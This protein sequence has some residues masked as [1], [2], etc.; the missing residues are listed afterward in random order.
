MTLTTQ[1]ALG[2][3]FC[4][5]RAVVTVAQVCSVLCL[6]PITVRR[7]L[8]KHGYYSSINHNARYYT[9]AH[10]PHFAANGLWFYRSIAFSC[11]RTL[12]KT[13]LALVQQ[14]TAGATPE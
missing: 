8:K 10:K 3:D 13:L 14:A 9:L 7:A 5:R 4:K 6:A 2:V 11:H 12:P 1:E